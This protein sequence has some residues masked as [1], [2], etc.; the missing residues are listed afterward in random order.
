MTRKPVDFVKEQLEAT[1]PG[2]EALAHLYKLLL[3]V[4]PFTLKDGTPVRVE[5]YEPPK[6]NAAGEAECG[7]DVKLPNGHLEF[8]LRNSGWGKAFTDELAN[9]SDGRGRRR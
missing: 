3:A 2:M 8:T 1:T 4:P 9:K 7:V 6:I 5:A